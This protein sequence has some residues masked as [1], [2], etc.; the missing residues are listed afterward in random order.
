MGASRPER[1]ALSEPSRQIELTRRQVDGEEVYEYRSHEPGPVARKVQFWAV[2]AV[3]VAVGV[4]LFLF[5]AAMLF[6]VLVPLL[7]IAVLVVLVRRFLLG[8]GG[9]I[10]RR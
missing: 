9:G 5:L 10:A 7:A 1:N 4:A 6:Y 8:T 2:T 3:G